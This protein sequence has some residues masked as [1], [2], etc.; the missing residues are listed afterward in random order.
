MSNFEQLDLFGNYTFEHDEIDFCERCKGEYNLRLSDR[1][2]KCF[3][4]KKYDV[5]LEGIK[6]VLDKY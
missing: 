4:S 2:P 5:D 6:R 3:P 1:C